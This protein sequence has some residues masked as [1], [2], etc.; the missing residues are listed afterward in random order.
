MVMRIRSAAVDS[1]L[2]AKVI[3]QLRA[4]SECAGKRAANSDMIFSRSLL[5]E[6][7]VKRHHLK[8]LNGL[9]F[10]L[11]SNPIDRLRRY[12]SELML[13]DV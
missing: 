13:D 10:Q 8:N 12:E 5:P 9:N 1:K 3:H 2:L 7:W 11:R 4:A 6:P